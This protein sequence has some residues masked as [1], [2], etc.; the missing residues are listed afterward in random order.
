M[1]NNH[2]HNRPSDNDQPA[3][4]GADQNRRREDSSTPLSVTRRLTRILVEEGEG[5]LLLQDEHSVLQWLRAMDM[6]LI[7]ACR[8]DERLKPLLKLNASSGVVDDP[9]LSH[10]S[11]VVF[12][13]ILC[14]FKSLSTQC[15]CFMKLCSNL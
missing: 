2:L 10:L 6:Q 13:I 4:N 11:Q 7:G 5:D 3:D 15:I 9:L 12:I 1:D 14:F 8:A